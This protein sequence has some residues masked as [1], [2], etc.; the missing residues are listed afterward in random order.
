MPNTPLITPNLTDRPVHEPSSQWASS[1]L[2]ALGPI[3][4]VQ[5]E[6]QM[7][8]N[9][10]TPGLHVPGAFPD[11]PPNAAVVQ[12]DLQ[13]LKDAALNALQTAK[14]YVPTNVG[15]GDVKRL[16]ENTGDTV[17]GYLPQSVTAYLR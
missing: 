1:T 9:A 5:P 15:L 8:S 2:D 12:Q 10:T 16:I 7:A 13:Y 14:G 3:S 4:N 11:A 6:D 17:G